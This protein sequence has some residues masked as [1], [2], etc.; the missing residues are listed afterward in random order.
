MHFARYEARVCRLKLEVTS[1]VAEV[2][3]VIVAAIVI[4]SSVFIG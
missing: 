2:V 3:L 1:I 4:L